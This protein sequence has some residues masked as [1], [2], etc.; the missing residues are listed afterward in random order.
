MMDAAP[1]T[2]TQQSSD[3]AKSPDI[4]F[5]SGSPRAYTCEALIDIIES[6]AKNAGAL[7][8]R[9]FL[10]NKRIEP[11][12]GC[13]SCSKTGV[14][15]L[16]SKTDGDKFIDDYLELKAALERAD[17]LAVVAPL[18]F[19]GPPAQLKALF[20][21]LQPYW[22]KRYVLGV[23]S[24]P[25]RPA[26]L[27]IV[28]GGD[29]FGHDPHGYEPLVGIAKSALAVAGFNL[30]KVHNFVGFRTGEDKP[31][32]TLPAI[33]DTKNDDPTATSKRTQVVREPRSGSVIANATGV[34]A[35]D[36]T[37]AVA[38]AA[39]TAASLTGTFAALSAGG[40]AS[41]LG[42]GAAAAPAGGAASAPAGGAAAAPA[43]SVTASFAAIETTRQSAEGMRSFATQSQQKQKIAR[44]A[45]F[46]QR[47][48]DAGG[49]LARFVIWAKQA[50]HEPENEESA[51]TN[52]NEGEGKK[53][54]SASATE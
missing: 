20:D 23:E 31:V 40:A 26:Q 34:D 3:T 36:S 38:S 17:A 11:C 32:L 37:T 44:Q 18:Y 47:A 39:N 25:K 41:A 1:D 5:I 21:R 9:F 45:D 42:G 29:D 46:E 2:L 53:T 16:A 13:N 30:E 7:S 15:L 49:A 22:A 14:C 8:R 51:A 48:H 6:G 10:S 54:L 50:R 27:F 33:M 35:S 52:L 28:G 24:Q 43:S 12:L 19:A 4:L